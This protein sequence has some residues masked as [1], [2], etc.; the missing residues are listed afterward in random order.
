MGSKYALK[1]EVKI[2]DFFTQDF[3]G[4]VKIGHFFCPILKRGN[5]FCQKTHFYCIIEFYGLVTEKIILNLLCQFFKIFC[6]NNLSNFS[7][8]NLWKHLETK[9]CSK[10]AR[11]FDV[12]CVT[13][14]RQR[15]VVLKNTVTA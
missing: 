12:S 11:I 2:F 1:F 14:Y 8:S 3:F 4:K 13:M 5:I 10:V 6:E 9:S 15:K 7:V